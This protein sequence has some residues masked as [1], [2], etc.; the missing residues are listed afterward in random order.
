[1]RL[2]RLVILAESQRRLPASEP[3]PAIDLY[4][5]VYFRVLKKYIREG[6][7]KHVDLLILTKNRGLV[8][9][10]ERL[11]YSEPSPGFPGRLMLSPGRVALLR[12]RNVRFLK[13]LLRRTK[14]GEIYVNVGIQFRRLL[15]GIDGLGVTITMAKGGGIGPKA[16]DMKNWIMAL[17]E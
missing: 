17:P 6:R 1:M 12:A 3:T 8:S 10:N 2:K 5:G 15:D 4:S 13:R 11:T 9:G 7:L 16:S 14:Y